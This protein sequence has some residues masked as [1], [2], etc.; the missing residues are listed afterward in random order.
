MCWKNC[1]L[2]CIHRPYSAVLLRKLLSDLYLQHAVIE[3]I[4]KFSPR[5]SASFIPFPTTT[6]PKTYS[7]FSPVFVMSLLHRPASEGHDAQYAVW[8]SAKLLKL[9]YTDNLQ[10]AHVIRAVACERGYPY[11]LEKMQ[12]QGPEKG[13]ALGLHKKRAFFRGTVRRSRKPQRGF[14]SA[15]VISV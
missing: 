2:I 1:N 8:E 3:I 7:A 6:F 14:G 12:K 15:S 13:A 4:K 10:T 5:K 11:I 9:L